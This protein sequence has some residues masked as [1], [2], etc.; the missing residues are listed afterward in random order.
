MLYHLQNEPASQGWPMAD[1]AFAQAPTSQV[2][3]PHFPAIP[4]T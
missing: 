4:G 3:P 2:G 1:G